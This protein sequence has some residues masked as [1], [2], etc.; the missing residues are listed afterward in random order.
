MTGR[1]VADEIVDF[2]RQRN[3]TRLIVGKPTRPAWRSLLSGSP[4]D[5]LVRV[6]RDIDVYV[7]T[8][9][10]VEQREPAY[11][12]RPKRI[13]LSDYGAGV[14]YLVLAT[15]ICFLMYPYFHLSNLIMVYLLGVMLTATGCGRGPA[16]LT[17][18][19]SVLAFDFFFVP[20]RFSFTVEESQYIVTFVVM[21]L[22]ALVIS[23]LAAGMRQQT[24]I[25]RLQERQAAA[26]HGLSRQLA[27]TRGVEKIL[28]LAV[29]Y[30]SEIFDCEVSALLP[31]EDRK[32]K[33]AAG[34]LSS[35]IQKDI[36]NEVQVA[37]AAYDSGQMAGWGT[38]TSPTTEN[39]LRALAGGRYH[40]R[41]SGLAAQGSPALSPPGAIDPPGLTGQPG[42]ARVG[43][44]AHVLAGSRPQARE[45]GL[46]AQAPG[47]PAARRS[48]LRREPRALRRPWP[49]PSQ[50]HSDH[51]TMSA[52]AE[53]VLASLW[54]MA[55]TKTEFQQLPLVACTCAMTGGAS[56]MTCSG[57]RSPFAASLS[58]LDPSSDAFTCSVFKPS[59]VRV[60]SEY[61]YDVGV[62]VQHGL[63][64]QVPPG[65]AAIVTTRGGP[66][67]P[68][69]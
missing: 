58:E 64:G 39:P 63:V 17:S 59:A 6:S 15:A 41:R 13:H 23:H 47:P 69:S 49:P 26:M 50:W 9:E 30:I 12:I 11:V 29:Q 2:A 60:R 8:G 18:F 3:V 51:G 62:P 46:T 37:H 65:A 67:V 31:D 52:R 57:R 35:V 42:C 53:K 55:F 43:S 20:P 40:V 25:A 5:R 56:G 16:I 7:T 4:V 24:A 36:T 66:T 22:V 61:V 34:D 45:G 44:G 48:L 21:A 10:P 38:Q 19:L 14:L 27:S 32:L 33:V 68:A 1:D 28:E 54:M